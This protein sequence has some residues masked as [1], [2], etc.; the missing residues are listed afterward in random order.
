MHS[1]NVGAWSGNV[2]SRIA[3]GQTDAGVNA[4]AFDLAVNDGP[5]KD[6]KIWIR[7]N[8]FGGLVELCKQRLKKGVYLQVAG[9]V[10]QRKRKLE[11]RAE[12]IVF[13]GAPAHDEKREKGNW[14]VV[15][16]T[17]PTR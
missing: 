15:P 10:M 13:G 17:E 8:V 7:I 16:N 2:G 4:C 6:Q 14:P 3:F 12:Q 5:K 1:I 9:S 11:V